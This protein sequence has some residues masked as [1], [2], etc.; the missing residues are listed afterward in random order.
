MTSTR[1]ILFNALSFVPGVGALPPVKARLRSRVVGAVASSSA[2]YCYSVWMRHLVLAAERGVD[3]DFRVV[4]E[5]GPGA[6]LGIGLA[7]LLCGCE[8]YEGFDV[9]RHAAAARNREILDE[10][11]A[12]LRARAPIPDERE[13][14][15]VRPTLHS[16]AFPHEAL[17]EARLARS[18]SPARIAAI[19]ASLD[20]LGAPD[21]A[22]A[23]DSMI[24]YRVPWHEDS[25]I[26]EASVDAV[27]SQAVFEHIDDIGGAYRAIWRWLRPGGY[28]SHT[29]DFRSHGWTREWDG[30]WSCSDLT[31]RLIRGRDVWSI[32]REPCSTHRALLLASGFRIIGEQLARTPATQS[33]ARLAGRFRAMTEDDRSISGAFFQTI[34]TAVAS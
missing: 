7:A 28:A 15:G 30:H 19:R 20:S 23:A 5:L 6:S 29:I 11:I 26:R 21:S 14:P 16:Y 4:A 27:I 22:G 18:L 34:K 2:R 24:H 13:F 9:V 10:L 3:T 32:N 25:V 33:R 12:L 8:R 17:S 31:W 1:R